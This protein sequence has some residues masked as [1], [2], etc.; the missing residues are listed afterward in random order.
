MALI[1]DELNVRA[2]ELVELATADE[3]LGVRTTLQVNARAAGPRLGKQVQSAIRASKSGDWSVDE[4]G[5]VSAGGIV[6]LEDEFSLQTVIDDAGADD[7]RAVQ[8]L[9]GGGFVIMNTEVTDELAAEGLARD[10]VRAVQ[11]GRRDAG[12]EVSNRIRVTLGGDAEVRSAIERHAELIK[13]ETLAVVLELTAAE[14]GNRADL[15]NGRAVWLVDL[16][17]QG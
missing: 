13:A 12:L 9:P 4:Q 5:A 7:H 3:G 10:V 15:G 17:L 16:A 8:T 11:Q 2:V 14:S 6:L 1:A